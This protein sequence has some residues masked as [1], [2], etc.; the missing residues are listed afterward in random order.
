MSDPHEEPNLVQEHLARGDATGWF[1]VVYSNASGDVERVPWAR[2]EARPAFQKWLARRQIEGRGQCAMVV[3]SG[4]G[5]DAEALAA[6]GFGV[7]AFDISPTAIEW[8]RR[9]F[10]D[11]AVNYLVA[12]LFEPP[13]DWIGAFDLVVEIYN[14]QALPID[15]RQRACAAV[16]RLVAPG[17][18]LLVICVGI[19]EDRER[20]GPPWP[21]TA[22]ELA[23]FESNDLER[24]D[25]RDTD[26]SGFGSR[27]WQIEYLRAR[28]SLTTCSNESGAL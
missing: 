21:F 10:P 23:F 24:V 11:S 19:D 4:L 7:T 27:I 14:V 20:S 17:G 12:D 22:E 3:G 26:S 8:S 16:T 5:D 9:R 2:Q 28:P 6:L 13:A 15:M 18:I 1:D 25:F